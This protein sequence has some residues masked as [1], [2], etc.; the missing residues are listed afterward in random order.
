VVGDFVSAARRAEKA[1]FSGVEIHGANGYLFT[2]FLAPKDNPRTD[3]YGGDLTNRARFLRETLRA[4]RAAVA[5]QFAVGVRISPVD[6]WDRR[7][8][9]LDDGAQLAAWLAE[10]GADF[11]HLSLR[12]ASDGPPH[13]QGRGPVARAVRDAVPADVP[14]LAAGGIW[15]RADASRAFAAGVDVVALGRSAIAHP[16]WPKVSGGTDWTPRKPPWDPIHLREAGVGP[17]FLD[18]LAGFAGMVVGGRGARG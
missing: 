7:G 1:G 18:Y 12:G 17:A 2:Q 4:V 8:L 5:A 3:E 9:T 15:T 16:D 14:I 11:I 13:E 6:V 10:D